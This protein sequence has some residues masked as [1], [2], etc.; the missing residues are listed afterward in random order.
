MSNLT[1]EELAEQANEPGTFSF[2]ER[3]HGRNY[4][5]DTVTIY[6]NEELGYKLA[7]LEVAYSDKLNLSADEATALQQDIDRLR[8]EIAPEKYTFYLEGISN[9][10]YDKLVSSA[11][12]QFPYEYDEAIDPWNGAKSKILIDVYERDEYF[13]NIWWAATIRKVEF[14]DGSVDTGITSEFI[15]QFRRLGPINALQRVGATVQKLRMATNW[16]EYTED[17]DFLAKP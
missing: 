5:K 16:I 11:E 10:Y 15:E 17:E 1:P 13:T 9:E 14:A 4:A 7:E 12:E 2:I 3:L 8:G 6:L